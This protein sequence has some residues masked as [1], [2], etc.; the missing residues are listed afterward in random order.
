[1][2][3][4]MAQVGDFLKVAGLDLK[5]CLKKRMRLIG[6]RKA[7]DLTAGAWICRL[8]DAG[9]SPFVPLAD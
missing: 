4:I 6:W 1:M 5:V 3:G 8:L 7:M 9:P 2:N